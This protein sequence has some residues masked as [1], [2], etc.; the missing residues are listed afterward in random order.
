MGQLKSALHQRSARRYPRAMNRDPEV[1][2]WLANYDNP[3]KPVV[4]AV[5]ELVTVWCADGDAWGR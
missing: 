4:E 1:D 5:R 2:G 3:Q